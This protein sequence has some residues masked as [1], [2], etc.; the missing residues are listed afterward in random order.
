MV[1]ERL[2]RETGRQSLRVQAGTPT[3]RV[4]LLKVAH[5]G[6][7]NSTSDKFL[8][9]INPQI[10]L[11]SAG[12]D[13]S[14]GHPHRE[15]LERLQEQ[16]SRIYQTPESGAVTFRIRRGRVQVEEFLSQR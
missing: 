13:N 7:K 12:R 2:S 8:T 9:L 10:A 11:I 3:E 15:T 6:S 4:T 14:Y 16:G 5:H 1:T